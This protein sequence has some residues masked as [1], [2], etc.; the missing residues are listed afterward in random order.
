MAT[1]YRKQAILAG[2]QTEFGGNG[3]THESVE[4]TITATMKNGSLLVGAT[5][6]A[7]ADAATVDGILDDPMIDD[8]FYEVG[9]KVLTRVAKRNV[10][11]NKDVLTF[12]DGAYTSETLTLLDGAGVIL[13]PADTNF[14]RN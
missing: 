4:V 10:I 9:D 1:S 6:A 11:A 2:V 5:E 14:T 13:Q 3:Y 8:G 12:S 7:I